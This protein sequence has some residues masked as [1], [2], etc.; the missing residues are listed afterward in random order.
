M[1]MAKT[2]KQK[3]N[4]CRR[5]P[6]PILPPPSSKSLASRRSCTVKLITAFVNR[7][8][9]SPA[10]LVSDSVLLFRSFRP[11]LQSPS[12]SVAFNLCFQLD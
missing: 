9:L 3:K 8:P 6:T 1:T 2:K 5:K 7:C 10:V 4:L 12:S 11:H